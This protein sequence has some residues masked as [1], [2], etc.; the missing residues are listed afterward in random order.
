MG[1]QKYGSEELLRSA[2]T[3]HLFDVYVQISAEFKPE[4]DEFKAA[5]RRGEDTSQLE[6]I[7]LFGEVKNYFRQ[8]EQGDQ[9]AL[10]LWKRFRDMSVEKY[11][12]SYSRLNIEFD[13][14][15]GESTVKPTTME[16]AERVLKEKGLTE[17]D[18]GALI[19]D[20]KKHGAKKLEKA[21]VRNRNGTTTYLLRDIGAAIERYERY[22]FDS[23]IYVIMAEQDV[24]VQRFFKILELMGGEYKEVSARCQHVNFGKVMGMSTRRGTARFLDDILR[25][26]GDRMHELMRQ[27]PEKY[28]QVEQPEKVADLL[29]ISAVMVQDMSGKRI[30]NYPF[31]MERMFSFEGDTGPYLQYAHARL[32]SVARKAGFSPKELRDADSSLLTEKHAVDLLRVMAQYPD[33]VGQT[34]KTQEPAT[35]LTYLFRLTHQLSS[36]YD[37]LRV[38]GASEGQPTSIARASL[39]EAARQVLSNGM[40]LLGLTPVER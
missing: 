22:Q 36:S 29:G 19:V 2:P 35:I 39:Y 6:S 18:Q 34:L 15:S 12:T 10:A 9:E 16:R 7:G 40:Q 8:M 21:I 37:V 11:K 30:N 38:V 1:W 32:S 31:D 14:Y 27:N 26:V 28:S 25:D 3:A 5:G 23:M 33:T 17:I 13:D 24:H 20:F 4:E